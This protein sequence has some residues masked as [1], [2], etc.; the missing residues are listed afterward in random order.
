MLK[1]VY[2]NFRRG[3]E[4]IKWFATLFSERMHIE[5][6]V[7]KLLYQ[8]DEMTRKRQELLVTIGGRVVELKDR[9]DKIVFHDS[10]V[11]GALA[12]I[13][14]IDSNIVELRQKASEISRVTG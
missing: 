10:V 8:S 12:E 3:A 2:E 9:S 11:A 14:K 4:K 6:A 1:K 7:F 13:E 5:L